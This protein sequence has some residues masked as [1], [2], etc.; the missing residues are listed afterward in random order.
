MAII[1]RISSNGYE[2]DVA[3]YDNKLSCVYALCLYV[4]QFVLHTD[5]L[6]KR[7]L[8]KVRNRIVLGKE[9]R[10]CYYFADNDVVYSSIAPVGSTALDGEFGSKYDYEPNY[11]KP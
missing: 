2:A 5:Y 7:E 9:N 8:A 10:G 6:N 11:P 1:H 4:C 3:E